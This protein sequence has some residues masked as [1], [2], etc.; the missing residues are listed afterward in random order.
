MEVFFHLNS[1]CLILL[2]CTCTPFLASRQLSI[3]KSPV[4]RTPSKSLYMVEQM[5]F[6]IQTPH[7][8]VNWRT[9]LPV[10]ENSLNNRAHFS[11]KQ[12]FHASDH[13]QCSSATLPDLQASREVRWE[14]CMVSKRQKN[15]RSTQPHH[16][17]SPVLC[18]FLI[19]SQHPVW[20]SDY[21]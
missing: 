6:S 4:A 21:C 16:V 2:P 19:F 3:H 1:I 5:T 20:F 18:S 12:L 8:L 17:G 7:L 13:L 15:H 10:L 11:E 9:V 14:L